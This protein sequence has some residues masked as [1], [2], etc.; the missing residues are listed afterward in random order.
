[1][2]RHGSNGSPTRKPAKTRRCSR[3]PSVR[4]L[5]G[6]GFRKTDFLSFLF[7]K[8]E[9]RV[10]LRK[11]SIEA[12]PGL[13]RP[14]TRFN[15]GKGRASNGGSAMP[16]GSPSTALPWGA[17]WMAGTR[18]AMTVLAAVRRQ[19]SLEIKNGSWAPRNP[20]KSLKTD[21]KMFGKVWRFQAKSLDKFGKSL[22]KAW[23]G[24]YG[25]RVPL[26]PARAARQRSPSASISAS[27]S[28]EIRSKTTALTPF[29][30]RKTSPVRR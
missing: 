8:I 30:S 15:S 14:S 7:P 3:S 2:R 6:A 17:A 10:R 21:E 29:S 13:S 16:R 26:S 18:P 12:W 20:L 24:R 11:G 25:A 19:K 1:M 9:I 5:G 22:E 23:I 27:S 28:G 4:A